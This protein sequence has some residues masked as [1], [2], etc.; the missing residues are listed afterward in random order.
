MPFCRFCGTRASDDAIFCG[1]CGKTL[2]LPLLEQT[3]LSQP[4]PPVEA[5]EQ[6]EEDKQRALPPIAPLPELPASTDVPGVQGTPQV[7]SV[8]SVPV[9]A[10][11]AKAVGMATSLKIVLVVATCVVVIAT[12]AKVAPILLKGGNHSK[13]SAQPIVTTVSM[14]PTQTG[15]PANGQGRSA[16]MKPLASGNDQNIVYIDNQGSSD[17]PVSGELKRFNVRTGNT[18]N[19][20]ILPSTFL[21]KAQV[22]TDGKWILLVSDMSNGIAAIQLIRMDGQ[23]LQ[24]LYCTQTRNLSDVQWS[25]NQLSIAFAIISSTST[26]PSTTIS[27]LNTQDG[28]VRTVATFQGP[29]SD[30]C[31]QLSWLDSIHL[32]IIGTA[33]L[34]DTP[35]AGAPL[36]LDTSKAGIQQKSNIPALFQPSMP[37]DGSDYFGEPCYDFASGYHR[38]QVFVSQCSLTRYFPMAADDVVQQGP[39]SISVE[40]VT[41]GSL[42]TIYRNPGFAIAAIQMI[43]ATRLLFYVGNYSSHAGQSVDT[44]QNGLWTI[45]SDGTVLKHLTTAAMGEIGHLYFEVPFPNWSVISLDGSMYASSNEDYNSGTITLFYG[46]LQG[47]NPT[48]FLSRGFTYTPSGSRNGDIEIIGWTSM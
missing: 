2:T 19:I 41:G 35:D 29:F 23:G 34:T 30:C 38:S 4:L 39:S 44:S 21:F 16:I 33:G 10:T 43:S 6:G 32:T 7:G 20:L 8:P 18:T 3:R 24:T 5:N 1:N 45:N 13:T 22:S 28:Q 42:Q 31:V 37:A 48:T 26:L 47:G 27:L 12:T 14:P 15:C 36:L 40:P 11:A 46:S 9:V 25:P 17:S